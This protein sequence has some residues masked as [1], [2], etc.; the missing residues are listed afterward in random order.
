MQEHYNIIN[1]YSRLLIGCRS[2]TK[3]DNILLF[4]FFA[5]TVIPGVCQSGIVRPHT[6]CTSFPG[7]FFLARLAKSLLFVNTTNLL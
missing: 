3:K 7:C 4:L 2:I 6:V 5:V 1:V